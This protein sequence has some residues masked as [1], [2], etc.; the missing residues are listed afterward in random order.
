M[1]ILTYDNQD[2][3]KLK[4]QVWFNF[5]KQIKVVHCISKSKEEK[6]WLS[7]YMQKKYYLKFNICSWF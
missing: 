4:M 3:F 2:G 5:R 7:L 6:S 1:K